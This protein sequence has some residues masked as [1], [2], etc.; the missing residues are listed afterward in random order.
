MVLGDETFF[1]IELCETKHNQGVGFDTQS[2]HLGRLKKLAYE[3]MLKGI[4][5]V[6]C[7]RI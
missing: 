3:Y 4:L 2:H 7:L 5:Q 1:V 6:W